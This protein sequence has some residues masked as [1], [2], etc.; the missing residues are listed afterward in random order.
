MNND[1]GTRFRLFFFAASLIVVAIAALGCGAA[2]EAVLPSAPTAGEIIPQGCS[3]SR[4]V[5][6]LV[7]DWKGEDRA[8][9]REAETRGVAVVRYDC[10]VLEVLTDCHL[11]GEYGYVG[12]TPEYTVVRFDTAGEIRANLPF[13]GVRLAGEIGQDRSLQLAMATVGKTTSRTASAGT[14]QLVGQCEGATHFVRGIYR[15]A[16]AMETAARGHTR[17][18]AD[19]LGASLE[20]AARGRQSFRITSGGSD[21][22]SEAT[23]DSSSPP[24][25]CD[26][27]LKLE[28]RRIGAAKGEHRQEVAEETDYVECPE[29]FVEFEGLCHP[30]Q[31]GGAYACTPSDARECEEQCARGNQVSCARLAYMLFQGEG[32]VEKDRKRALE[33]YESSCQAG[34]QHGCSGLGLIYKQGYAGVAVDLRRSFDLQMKACNGGEVRGCNSLGVFFDEGQVVEENPEQAL[35]LYGRACEGG[36]VLACANQGKLFRDGRGVEADDEKAAL[37]FQQACIGGASSGCDNLRQLVVDGRAGGAPAQSLVDRYGR[38]CERG[39]TPACGS[40]A[41]IYAAEKSA[42]YDPAKAETYRAMAQE[43][44]DQ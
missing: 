6:P 2:A 8:D 19:I 16:F 29:G 33:L 3:N 28:L 25:R 12:M 37:L 4:R 43:K 44:G 40:L 7:V 10:D 13:S 42:L 15:G 18:A 11:P 22:C 39:F 31:K 30:R 24:A 14:D 32:R 35:K 21:A 5:R 26:I 34:V 41:K 20:G 36:Y 23:V 1:I 9:L 17:S 38:E 27:P